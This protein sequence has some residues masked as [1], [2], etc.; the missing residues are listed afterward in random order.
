[1]HRT[2]RLGHVP[3]RIVSLVPSQTEL[4]YDLGLGD[5]VVGITKFCI[6]PEEWFRS[7]TR[8]GGTK[9]VDLDKVKA[10]K[11]DLIIGNKEENEKSDIL[12]LEDVAP[13]WMSDIFTLSDS[14]KMILAL[15]EILKLEDHAQN[16]VKRIE[17]EFVA[18]EK[19]KLD[20]KVLYLIW[21]DPYMGVG[22]NTF[23]DHVLHD[24]LGATN[25]LKEERYPM[26]ELSSLAEK[27]EL[28]LLSSEP[29]PFKEKHVAEIQKILPQA[30]IY[31]VD[32]EYF[33]WYG[34]RL[35]GAPKYFHQLFSE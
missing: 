15:G 32:G 2:I 31:L 3:E 29:Y 16:M 20:Q 30:K 25:V 18:L 22:P 1:M 17:Q 27:P 9:N 28:V 4:L 13:V 33:S 14:L 34:S 21:K 19:L 23:I 7:K 35:L 11:P 24:H 5:R 10:L 8:V 6:H 12:A 26:I